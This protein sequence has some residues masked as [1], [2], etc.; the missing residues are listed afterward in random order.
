MVFSAINMLKSGFIFAVLVIFVLGII[1]LAAKIRLS[2]FRKKI[3]SNQE[4]RRRPRIIGF[5]HPFC[6]AMGGGEKVLY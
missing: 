2:Q 5:F 1:R 6:D 4:G 3:A